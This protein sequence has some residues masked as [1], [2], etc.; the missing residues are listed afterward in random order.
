MLKSA[1]VRSAAV[2]LVLTAS[3]PIAAPAAADPDILTPNCTSGQLPE[4]GEC[5]P[6]PGTGQ[7]EG[8][9]GPLPEVP[10]GIDPESAP[11]I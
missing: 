7:P 5:K 9:P 4:T 11:A 3:L 6:D 10:L 8:V 1:V 2:G